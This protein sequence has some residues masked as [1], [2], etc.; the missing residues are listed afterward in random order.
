MVERIT[1]LSSAGSVLGFDAVHSDYVSSPTTA[2]SRRIMGELGAAMRFGYDTPGELVTGFD[3]QATV[4][5]PADPAI[6]HGRLPQLAQLR[7]LGMPD[8]YLVEAVRI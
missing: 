6:S 5:S 8:L 1:R 3:W 4:R 7:K 2:H